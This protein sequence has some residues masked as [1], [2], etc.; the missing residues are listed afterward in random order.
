MILKLVFD[1]STSYIYIPDGFIADLKLL[2]ANFLDWVQAQPNC[3]AK[4]SNQ[5]VGLSFSEDDFLKY[6][7]TTVLD[8]CNEKAFMLNQIPQKEFGVLRF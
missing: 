5:Y 1:V 8:N 6:L 7:N 2:E 3:I 4:V